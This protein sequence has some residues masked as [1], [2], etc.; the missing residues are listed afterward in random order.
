M[1]IQNPVTTMGVNSSG[2][3]EGQSIIDGA[4]SVVA[5]SSAP[6]GVLVVGEDDDP[7]GTVQTAFTGKSA[8]SLT[9]KYFGDDGAVTNN[10]WI[11]FATNPLAD[12]D[13]ATPEFRRALPIGSEVTIQF[14]TDNPLTKLQYLAVGT[15]TNT[16]L[17]WEYK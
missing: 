14:S 12:T 17:V 8:T 15:A 4:A 5:P 16:R 6:I 11:A 7:A 13:V 1:A 9:L 2:D 3:S 10:P